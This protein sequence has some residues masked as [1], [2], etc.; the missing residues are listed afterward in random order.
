MCIVMT[1]G[2]L[3]CATPTCAQVSDLGSLQF[4]TRCAP[5]AQ[6]HFER[7]VLALHSFWFEEA[8]DAFRSATRADARCVMGLW[9]EAMAH[10]HPLWA[11]QDS[12]AARA[13]MA[14][15]TDTRNL[16]AKERAW[17]QA[18]QLLYGDGDKLARDK[19]YAGAMERMYHK[20]PDDLE[21][22]T[23]YAL[24]LLGTVRPGDKGFQRQMKAGA[25]ALAVLGKNPNH[26]GAAHFVIHSF[27]DPEHAIL[28][29]PAAFRYGKIAPEAHHAR[30]M[31]S[32]IFIQL[33]MWPEGEAS[34]IS[35]WEASVNWVQQK[36]LS[37]ARQDLHSLHW[38][39]YIA[40][41]QGKVA[42]AQEL[43]ALR[44]Q[45]AAAAAKFGADNAGAM[46]TSSGG[47]YGA[48]MYAA[49]VVETE[50]WSRA[51]ELFPLDAS[52]PPPP[53]AG[54]H[55]H[56]TAP[57]AGSYSQMEIYGAFIRGLAAAK[58]G[59]ADAEKEIAYL[60]EGARKSTQEGDGYYGRSLEVM[61]R[62]VAAQLHATRG[63][64]AAASEEMQQ[65]TLIE[66]GMSPPSGPP[67]LI[68]PSHEL[69]G[70]ILLKAGKGAEAQ[71]QFEISL[72][73]QPN[74]AR[75]LLGAARAATAAGRAEV[76]RGYY[77]KLA[78]IWKDADR[79]LAELREVQEALKK[80]AVRAGQE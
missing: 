13:V 59:A 24:S 28:A 43:V 40:L 4:P 18:L 22:A 11:E 65:A 57:A 8:L 32:H 54:E 53:A 39:M 49:L 21:V 74:R 1:A 61:A 27:D 16:T 78:G 17:W 47:R 33:G 29:L 3:L 46:R 41:Q 50:A 2:F 44:N 66:E 10:N 19:A 51:A 64:F 55:V 70:E 31:P 77:D 63:N 72:Q 69:F 80:A 71:A 34:N 35:A 58:R 62:N 45:T 36:K 38:W 42:K 79:N 76:A 75:S 15:V 67:D 37:P 68:K 48:Y 23:F 12:E 5:A 20:Y 25:I 56:G 30:H 7:G 60:K 52:K 6:P 9:G 14:R 73:R 26:P